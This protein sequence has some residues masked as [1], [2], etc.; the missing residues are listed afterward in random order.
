MS[1]KESNP[2]P[3]SIENKPKPPPAPPKLRR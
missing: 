1:K 2:S 3:P